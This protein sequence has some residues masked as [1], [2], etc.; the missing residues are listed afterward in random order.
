VRDPVNSRG[1]GTRVVREFQPSR[2]WTEERLLGEKDPRHSQAAES[3]QAFSVF[4]RLGSGAAGLYSCTSVGWLW[5]WLRDV[6][7]LR[8]EQAEQLHKSMRD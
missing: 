3:A 2:A 1:N 7:R 4:G 5:G 8:P 6:L